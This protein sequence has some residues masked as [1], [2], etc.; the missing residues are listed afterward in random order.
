VKTSLWQNEKNQYPGERCW[1][2]TRV[3][4]AVESALQATKAEG[5]YIGLAQVGSASHLA[6]TSAGTL[7]ETGCSDSMARDY[8]G[9]A[10]TAGRAEPLE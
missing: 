10:G 8:L 1:Q 7:G 4:G 2:R 3:C 6:I 9:G 5:L